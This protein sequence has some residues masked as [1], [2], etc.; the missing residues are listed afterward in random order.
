MRDGSPLKLRVPVEP[1]RYEIRYVNERDHKVLGRRSLTVVLATATLVAPAAV[2]AKS[3][4]EVTWTGPNGPSDYV[5]IVPVGAE[6]GVYTNYFYTRDGSTGRLTAPE[7]PGRYELRYVI[8][9][10]PRVIGRRPI[11]VE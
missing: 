9:A 1:G 4:F 10:G 7:K 11:T 5:T 3:E 6:P 2:K 8:E